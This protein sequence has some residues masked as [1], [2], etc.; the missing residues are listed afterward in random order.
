MPLPLSENRNSLPCFPVESFP[1]SISEYIIALAENTQTSRD[2]AAVIALG[3][4]S[5]ASGRS[6]R[7]EGNAN[8]Y[9]PLN[10]YVLLVA[11][12]GERK[13][14]IMQN[15]TRFLFDYEQTENERLKPQITAYKQTKANLENSIKNLQER[16]GK[17]K[18]D[19]QLEL[20]IKEKQAEL[21]DLQEVK[22]LR[23]YADDCSS[24]ALTT[25][26]A[27]NNGVMAV[28]SAEGSIFDII[29][30]RYNTKI[31]MDVWLK[32]HSGDEIRVDRKNRLAEY[33]AN[34]R[35]TTVLT[36]QPSV[37]EEIMS[38]KAMNGRGLI[39]RFLIAIPLSRIGQRVF[40]TQGIP[41]DTTDKFNSVLCRI[42]NTPLQQEPLTLQLSEEARTVIETYFNENEILLS[43]R[44]CSMRE[45]L[46]K[47]VGQ[48][49]RIAGILHLASELDQHTLVSADTMQKA[50]AIGRYFRSHAKY[51][52]TAM[53]ADDTTKKA[54]FVI[55]KL[56]SYQN[57]VVKRRDVFRDCRGT[58]FKNVEE[59][60]PVLNI[61]E[62]YGYIRQQSVPIDGTNRPSE[63]IHINP[64]INQQELRTKGTIGTK[65]IG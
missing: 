57:P 38:N 58:Y 7:I 14:S 6:Y 43:D 2:M 35:L 28:L 3:I 55:N 22:P 5:V 49:L 61:L 25:L 31:N 36:V 44:T 24:E 48:V 21:D 46:A 39:A 9:E 13:S 54:E 42:L 15:M 53:G 10:L 59:L 56:R 50:V 47:N 26:L 17:S 12:P 27:E 62:E 30:G 4:L 19:K 51:A 33:I 16:L 18:N 63:I 60:K 34:P 1:S 64:L 37:L 41:Q 32:G 52:Y 11:E 65:E 40:I 20:E 29:A 8:Y 23:L 45:W